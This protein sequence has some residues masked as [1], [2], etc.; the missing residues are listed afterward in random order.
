MK[1][2][3]LLLSVLVI[4]L[5]ISCQ[6]HDHVYNEWIVTTEPTCSAEGIRTRSCDCGDI[7]TQPI[8]KTEHVYGE[9][10]VTTDATCSEEGVKAR[11]CACGDTQTEAI[12]KTEHVYG[13]WETTTEP[14]CSEEGVKARVCACGDTQTETI[15]KTE[16][17]FGEWE[18]STE[19]TCSKEGTNARLCKDCGAKDTQSVATVSHNWAGG[20]CDEPRACANCGAEDQTVHLILGSNFSCRECGKV[21]TFA[22]YSYLARDIFRGIRDKEPS[23]KATGARM[24]MYEAL[25][26]NVYALISVSY[27]VDGNTTLSQLFIHNLPDDI[28]GENGALYFSQ[29]AN[30]YGTNVINTPGFSTYSEY[31]KLATECTFRQKYMDTDPDTITISAEYLNS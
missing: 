10:K 24:L 29:L 15:A 12:A 31:Q 25:N 11:V 30:L 19:P 5:L 26:G 14:T 4:I 28:T 27:T 23:A 16:H 18:V 3:F 7:Q 2:L 13:E 22:D 21:M 8:E 1:K 9:W 20:D 6:S 17:S